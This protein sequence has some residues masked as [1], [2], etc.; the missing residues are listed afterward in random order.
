MQIM[1]VDKLEEKQKKYFWLK[2]KED[3]FSQ[4]EIKKLRKIAGGDTYTIIY[5]KMQLKTIKTNGILEYESLED[6]F[7]EELALDLDEDVENVKL[8]LA[9][10]TN[11]GLI[12]Q[13]SAEEYIL[14]KVLDCIGSETKVAERVR[15]HRANKQKEKQFLLQCN[16]EVT[17]CNTDIE[18]DI[19]KEIELDKEI[20]YICR[21][22]KNKASEYEMK[23]YD[24]K[25]HSCYMEEKFNIFW[26]K[27]P[28]KVSKEKAK[29]AFF[30]I[31]LD[32]VMFSKILNALEKFKNTNDWIKEKGQYIPYPAT[33]LNQ[34]RWEDE[35]EVDISNNST[36]SNEIDPELEKRFNMKAGEIYE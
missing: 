30:K 33:W 31:F 18:I 2:L 23:K 20:K 25:C 22:C 26:N 32:D 1:G 35:F 17:K 15:K 28:K 5:L 13:L 10:L 19:E 11:H 9:F 34:K 27:Y 21:I 12:E 14:P 7:Y 8:T 3:F 29:K 36:I 6:T 4:K 16:N 24:D